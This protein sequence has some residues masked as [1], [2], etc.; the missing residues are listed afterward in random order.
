MTYQKNL[1]ILIFTGDESQQVI[2]HLT[3]QG[4]P[5]VSFEDMPSQIEHLSQAGQHRIISNDMPSL[6]A[7]ETLKHDFPTE[8]SLVFVGSEKN[9][10]ELAQQADYS[11]SSEPTAIKELLEK[12]DFSL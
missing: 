5:K 8:V 12:L 7:Y 4:F 6:M 3:E 1:K 10:N 9:Q 2:D 11:V